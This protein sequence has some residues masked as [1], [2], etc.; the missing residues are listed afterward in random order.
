MQQMALFHSFLW[1]VLCVLSDYGQG[2]WTGRA[3]DEKL[4]YLLG[5]KVTGRSVKLRLELF[6]GLHSKT[7]L[8]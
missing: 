3:E 1:L 6:S 8:I 4:L 5:H 2:Y 7:V